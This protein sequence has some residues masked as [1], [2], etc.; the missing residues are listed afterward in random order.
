MSVVERTE[1]TSTVERKGKIWWWWWAVGAAVVAWTWTQRGKWEGTPAEADGFSAAG[2]RSALRRIAKG[3][4][5]QPSVPS[6]AKRPTSS[7]LKTRRCPPPENLLNVLVVPG[8]TSTPLEL[9]RSRPCAKIE[10]GLRRRLWGDARAAQAFLADRMC[11]LEH[12]ALD[13]NTGTDPENVAVRSVSGLEAVESLLG[14]YEV[15]ARATQAW[16]AEGHGVDGLSALTFDWRL[17]PEALDKRDAYFSRMRARIESMTQRRP[18]AVVT[19]SYASL[20]F[21]AFLRWIE[22]PQRQPG[23]TDKNVKAWVNLAGPIFGV[24]KALSALLSGEM[25][26][27][28]VMGE[29]GVFLSNAVVP[30]QERTKLFRTW[31]SLLT[32]LPWPDNR[33]WTAAPGESDCMLRFGKEGDERKTEDALRLLWNVTGSEYA[34]RCWEHRWAFKPVEHKGHGDLEDEQI[35]GPY[36]LTLP[37]AP[38]MEVYCLYGVGKPTER[39]YEYMWQ[40]GNI[41]QPLRLNATAHNPEKQL[42]YG[43]YLGDGDGTV[44]LMSLGYM[45]NKGWRTKK[46]NPAGM[47]VVTRE[48]KHNPVHFLKDMRGGPF[49]ADHVDILLNEDMLADL[50]TITG[51]DGNQLEDD[52]HSAIEELVKEVDI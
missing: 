42:Q 31:G 43:V 45:C 36:G 29:L 2:A 8:F 7:R 40:P 4:A 18:T 20:L 27:S 34:T 33:V 16:I 12:M 5:W 19:H 23:W 37:D 50:V 41:D 14:G 6:T 9:W 30:A 13:P 35:S 38:N 17:A 28:A 32:M 49:S 46:Y 3:V 44:P 11:W 25:K 22:S 1:K 24:P 26:D 48:Y 15:W 39:G 47:R 21:L 52:I 51:G 10:P